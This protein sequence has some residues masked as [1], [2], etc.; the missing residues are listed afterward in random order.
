M[1]QEMMV[2]ISV[3][4][5]VGFIGFL[6]LKKLILWVES[7]VADI[8]KVVQQWAER[9]T[10]LAV[11]LFSHPGRTEPQTE[12][13]LVGEDLEWM[14]RG[15]LS[16]G[17]ILCAFFAEFLLLAAIFG[18]L[19]QLEYSFAGTHFDWIVAAGLLAS[20]ISFG[21]TLVSVLAKTKQT[22]DHHPVRKLREI[23][24]SLA[25]RVGLW[26]V[27]LFG[28]AS[29][30][31]VVI[32]AAKMRGEAL[33][34]SPMAN[35]DSMQL[36]IMLAV[37]CFL[38]IIVDVITSVSVRIVLRM[39]LGAVTFACAGVLWGLALLTYGIQLVAGLV[40]Q[41]VGAGSDEKS[42][43]TLVFDKVKDLSGRFVAGLRS[44]FGDEEVQDAAQPP[45]PVAVRS[46]GLVPPAHSNTDNGAI[47]RAHARVAEVDPEARELVG[48]AASGRRAGDRSYNPRWEE[49]PG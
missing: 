16:F 35:G 5:L 17:L 30:G 45:S 6:I 9:A 33:L 39:V 24:A 40:K 43:F 29:V 8:L 18:P 4:V 26:L 44:I 21:D 20:L 28:L 25:I 1:D 49:Y 14:V 47:V 38:A 42:I 3:V 46:S 27:S 32:L 22:N 12:G 37:I 13:K 2:T 15:A 11:S 19:F 41:L 31:Y 10:E 48:V 36:I 7:S 34:D 23:P